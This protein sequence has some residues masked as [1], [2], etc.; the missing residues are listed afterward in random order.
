ME[1]WCEGAYGLADEPSQP[2]APPQPSGRTMADPFQP[3][4]DMPEKKL[5]VFRDLNLRTRSASVS[6]RDHI[7]SH[8]KAPWR[9]DVEREQDVKHSGLSTNEDVI[10]LVRES[11]D[12]IDEAALVLWQED[13]G[14]RVANIVPR[15]VG[16]LGITKYNAILQDFIDRVASPAAKAGGFLTDTGSGWQTLEDWLDPGP[17]DALRR[18]C[19]LANK[20]TGASHPR[21]QERWYEF[22]IE[23]HRSSAKLDPGQLARWLIEV[24]GWGEETA[25]GLAIDFEFACG[26]LNRYDLN[27]P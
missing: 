25:H 15:R 13:D 27:R 16:E 6:I 19:N 17:A 12:D 14:Y 18:F 23:A 10:A 4:V 21:D 5:E 8:V 11:S 24:D 3:L 1:N 20:S 2:M 22:L 26:L 9:H 7:L